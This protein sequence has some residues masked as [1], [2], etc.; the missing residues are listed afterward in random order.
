MFAAGVISKRNKKEEAN[1]KQRWRQHHKVD[2][3]NEAKDPMIW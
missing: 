1:E 3:T 2:K